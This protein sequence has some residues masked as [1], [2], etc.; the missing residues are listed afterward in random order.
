[1]HQ[2][3]P[4]EANKS[5][6]VAMRYDQF[7]NMGRAILLV[8]D[9]QKISPQ[10]DIASVES[11]FPFPFFVFFLTSIWTLLSHSQLVRGL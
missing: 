4:L 10:Q 1:M 11:Y 6:Y 9:D 7:I 3:R 5:F 8:L 2:K